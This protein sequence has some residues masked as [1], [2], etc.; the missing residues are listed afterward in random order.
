MLAQDAAINEENSFRNNL[1]SKEKRFNGSIS[2]HSKVAGVR[3]AYFYTVFRSKC[4]AQ[5]PRFVI[6][7]NRKNHV[8][9]GLQ[10]TGKFARNHSKKF[11]HRGVSRQ[12]LAFGDA[13]LGACS[14][15]EPTRID[16]RERRKRV[17]RVYTVRRSLR[18]I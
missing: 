15:R 6:E 13:P 1:K 14:L 17:S 10:R 8:G 11:D 16:E 18:T 3:I 2:R 7:K 9:C 12:Y 5:P 4:S